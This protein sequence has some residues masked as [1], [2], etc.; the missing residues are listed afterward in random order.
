[1]IDD[2]CLPVGTPDFRPA[3]RTMVHLVFRVRLPTN[4]TGRSPIC[5]HNNFIVI[6][7]VNIT[8]KAVR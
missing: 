8:G 4:N 5:Y 1:M 7:W 3:Y 2:L 6:I